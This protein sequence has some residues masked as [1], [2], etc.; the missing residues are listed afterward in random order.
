[1]FLAAALAAHAALSA[2]SGADMRMGTPDIK[3]I[4]ALAFSPQGILFLGD[5]ESGAVFAVDVADSTVDQSSEPM[6]VSEIDKKVA[7]ALGTAPD[8]IRLHDLAVHPQSQR[9]YLSV[10]R[11]KGD[12]AAPI[13]L[14]VDRKGYVEEVSLSNVRF[15][16]AMVTNVPSPEDKDRRGRSKRA[17]SITYL[18]YHDGQVYVAGLSNEEFASS[19]RRIPFPFRGQSGS[20]SLEIYHVAH[21]Q[22]ETHAPIRTFLPF[23]LEGQAHIVASYTCTPLVVFPIDSLKD[24][25]HVKGK[26][27]AEL[28]AG[29]SP[30]DII[31]VSGNGKERILV[32]NNRRPMMVIDPADV[33]KGESLTNPIEEFWGTDGIDHVTL[34]VTGVVQMADMNPAHFLM[35][36]RDTA[37]GLL[38]LRSFPKQWILR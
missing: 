4:G 2:S 7:S 35:I 30:I 34:P 37:T 17:A 24:G 23:E 26:T 18:A 21:G 38:N 1:M 13:L 29:N 9:A 3:S 33:T 27:V 14:R 6:R 10:S 32:A 16:K 8:Q 28:G 25:V 31:A 5:V 12:Q 22:F 20:S 15:S 11:G 36:Q 19:L